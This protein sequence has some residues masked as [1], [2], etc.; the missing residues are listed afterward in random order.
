MRR[1]SWL[2][3]LLLC[4]IFLSIQAKRKPQ[5]D[6]LQYITHVVKF[7]ETLSKIAREYGITVTDILNANPAL[8]D[9]NNLSPDQVLRIPNKG[10][11]KLVKSTNTNNNSL[12]PKVEVKDGTPSKNVRLHT[13]EKGQ[14]LYAISKM[15]NVTLEDLRKWNNLT[16]NNV[17]LGSQL[18]VNPNDKLIPKSEPPLIVAPPDIKDVD[19]HK[20]VADTQSETG[21]NLEKP[22]IEASDNVSQKELGK[23]FKSE[24]SGNTMQT[25]KG[26]GAPMTTTLGAMENTY[27]IMH[28]TLAIGTI[29]K[30]KNL[31]NSKVVYAKVIGKL[32][33]T[34]ENKH[35]IVRYTLGIKK[36]LQ[37]QNGKC[38]VQIEYPN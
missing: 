20:Q 33:D 6:T 2:L 23:L 5:Q 8:S 34:D 18:R 19:I 37:L 22:D 21:D 38:Y 25:S 1:Y 29:V 17:K 16:D 13:V 11:K 35:V 26:T 7:G 4:S 31:V 36:D 32:P 3:L 15:Y 27:F 30:I 24:I 10:N 9:Y 14:T 28:K 12:Q